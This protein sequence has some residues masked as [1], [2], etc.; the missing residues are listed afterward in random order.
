MTPLMQQYWEIKTLHPDKILL[1][2]MGDFFE[3]FFDD[4]VTAAPILG[5]ALTQRNK[6]SQDETP[7]CGMP[8]HSIAGPINRLLARGLKV[9]ICDQIEDPKFAKGLVKRAVTRIL[10][11]GMVYDP[12]T[13][14]TTSCHYLASFDRETV[15]FVEPTTGECFLVEKRDEKG[16]GQF[17]IFQTLPVAEVVISEEQNSDQL[18]LQNLKEASR[19]ISVFKNDTLTAK[20]RLLAYIESL[21]PE[22]LRTLRPFELR[23]WR[24]RLQMSPLVFRHLEIFASSMGEPEGSLFHAINRTQTSAGARLLREDLRF[25]L[26]NRDEIGT[27]LDAVESW[28]K[29]LASLKIMRQRLAKLGD[30]ERRLAKISQPTG[31]PRDLLTMAES[32]IVG[33]EVLEKISAYPELETL[34]QK[35]EGTIVEDPP[36]SVRQGRWIQEGVTPILDELIA[37]STNSQGLL[38]DLEERERAATQIPSLK[39][40]YNQ[41]FGYYIEITNT[42]KDKAPPHYK[43][44]QTLANAE[45]FYTE[46]LMELEKKVLSAQTRRQEVEQQIFD[47]L[48]A[49]VL[50]LSQRILEMASKASRLDVTTSLAWLSLEQNYVRPK[51]GELAMR[52]QA[53]RHPVV[54]QALKAR[55]PFVANSLS[56]EP[57]HCLLLT[58]PNMAGKSTLMRQVALTIMMAQMGSFV[59]ASEAELPIIESLFTRIGASDVLSQGLSTFMVEMTETAEM[60]KG[61]GP[62]SL[63][64]LDE[65][66][67]GT[68]TYDGMSLAQAILE[69][70]L[71]QSKSYTFFA[72]HYHELTNLVKDYPQIQNCHMSVQEK[73]NEIRF[74]H[75]LTAGPATKSYGIHV[76]ELAGLPK[77]LTKRA[78]QL[79]K[80][81]EM[82]QQT[83]KNE[84][85]QLSL[86]DLDFLETKP[87]PTLEMDASI[88]EVLASIRDFSLQ[89]STP[90]QALNALSQW[91][92]KLRACERSTLAGSC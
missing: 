34:A 67:R 75:T 61:A 47:D 79:L 88:Q 74:L 18:L 60:L 73:N 43:R 1:F 4:A 26:T 70:L 17:D 2:R 14:E 86:L 90:L 49:E 48:K 82:T 62:R 53:S 55:S 89:N 65:I 77:S 92:E 45:R 13:L 6:K 27:R 25:P 39:V 12:D 41:V 85:N 72:T 29:D 8:H 44:K 20:D 76:A 78:R 83:F 24:S 40:R 7:M 71:T 31:G 19:T 58:G 38:Q 57:S 59:P 81:K 68:S 64:I 3:M 91:Q 11:P 51:F 50:G 52:L 10:T 63:V 23:L 54:E 21:S 36:L 84:V 37:L 9:A 33:V 46:E 28:Q 66:G 35:I 30:L 87:V 56:L 42:H 80:E 32:L 5:I 15:A 69:H 22:A 16:T